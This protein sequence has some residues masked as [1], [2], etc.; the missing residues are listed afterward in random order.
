MKR[1]TF[2]ELKN[3]QEKSR[4]FKRKIR[5]KQDKINLLEYKE[6]KDINETISSLIEEILNKELN[7]IEEIE[8]ESE[9]LTEE[10]FEEENDWLNNSY[11]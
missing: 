1:P 8:P 3:L 11:K 6:I 2:K 7:N 9:N 5:Q 4:K 10:E